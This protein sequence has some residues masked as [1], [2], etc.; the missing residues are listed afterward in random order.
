MATGALLL[1]A[2]LLLL[3]PGVASA[4]ALLVQS[5]LIPGATISSAPSMA[6][7]VFN[8][9][10]NAT[11]T[12]TDVV[13]SAGNVLTTSPGSIAPGNNEM[14]QQSLPQLPD[15]TYT[16]NW[17]SESAQD[18]HVAKSSYTFQVASTGAAPQL[19]P[20]PMSFNGDPGSG[21]GLEV[22]SGTLPYIVIHWIFLTAG[23]V[24]LGALLIEVLVLGRPGRLASAPEQRL[25]QLARPR[26]WRFVQIAPAVALVALLGEQVA[27]GFLATDSL[28][29]ALSPSTIGGEL[30]SQYGYFAVARLILLIIA[31]LLAFLAR[32]PAAEPDP[33]P[34]PAAAARP[35]QRGAAGSPLAQRAW[36]VDRPRIAGIDVALPLTGIALVYMLLVAWS[37]HAVDISPL[38][39]GLAGDWVHLVG[40]GAWIGGI[41]ALAWGPLS[42]QQKLLPHERA[43]GV[44]PLL[45]RFSPI[46]YAAVA[47]LV[48]SGLFN[49]ANLIPTPGDVTSTVYGQ[50]AILK[51]VL[52]IVLAVLSASHTF[53]LRPWIGRMERAADSGQDERGIF[54]A[55]AEQGLGVLPERLRFE[56]YIGAVILLA[57]SVM[58][59]TKP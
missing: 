49:A 9:P 3:S 23:A 35:Q 24:W 40:T 5:N 37:G 13:D 2:F 43:Y 12:K 36:A 44:L 57:A 30:N 46:A 21:S 48:L 26:V 52:V 28:S 39:L 6:Q 50:L 8:E 4:H 56:A 31:L 58:S 17:R 32:V 16:V 18:G 7:W 53:L 29:S 42:L 45:D 47:G 27:Q 41:A 1:G 33:P 38:W 25:I 20:V 14:W 22:P 51:S 10:L 11:L 19:G 15:G 34:Q 54:E 55:D 59:Q